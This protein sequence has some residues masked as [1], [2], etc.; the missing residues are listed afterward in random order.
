MYLW[1]RHYGRLLVIYNRRKG[2][3]L[4]SSFAQQR[5]AHQ[6]FYEILGVE[7]NCDAKKLRAAYLEKIR[8]Y[9]PDTTPY[10]DLDE[11]LL[12]QKFQEIKEAY[13]ILSDENTRK[14]Y[15]TTEKPL[16]K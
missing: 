7:K 9:H 11:S 13:Q 5:K 3:R 6:G 14:R 16:R 15:D 12:R 2:D 4:C 1:R 8:E 10:K